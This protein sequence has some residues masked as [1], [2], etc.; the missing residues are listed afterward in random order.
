MVASVGGTTFNIPKQTPFTLTA[1]ATDANGDTV[2]YDWQEYDLG[3]ATV[4]VPNTDSDGNA[5]PLFRV[6]SPTSAGSRTFPSTQFILANLNVPPG[7]TAGFLTGEL[8]PA[9]ART[10]NFQVIARDNH[11]NGGGINTATVSVAVAGTG[12]FTVTAPNTN[13]TWFLNSNPTVTWS[14]GGTDQAPI[15]TANV[16]ILL[17]TDSGATFPTVLLASTPNTGSA[18]VTSPA[19]NTTT[20][21]IRIEPI[22]NIFFDVSDVDFI[23]SN[24]QATAGIIA[25]RIA[26]AGGRGLARV[27]VTMTGGSPS[28]RTAITNAFG[29]FQFENVDF[30]QTYTITPAPRK[31][32]TYSPVNIV[33]NHQAAATDVNFTAQ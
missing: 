28:T 14:V 29:Y 17:S 6:Y 27:Y 19:I 33:R 3:P 11:A 30:G 9:I 31:G 25:G 5:R 26:S 2:T 22:G 18:T 32:K 1:S 4:A 21:R 16:R 20:A 12:P 8:L 10:M 13:T 24:Q 15:N 7:T 23:I